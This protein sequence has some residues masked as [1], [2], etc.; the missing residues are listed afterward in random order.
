M[1]GVVLEAA[2][3][4]TAHPPVAGH[5]DGQLVSLVRA[6]DDRAFEELYARYRR[7]I[8]AYVYG[9]VSDHGRAEDVTQEVFVSALRRMRETERPIAFRPWIYEIAK[10]ACID[11]HRR[12]SRA[13]EVALTGDDGQEGGDRL[14]LAASSPQPE[15]AVDVKQRLGHLCGAF[16]GLSEAHHRILVLRELEGLSYRE[17]GERMGLSRPAVESTLFRARRRLA[18]EYDELASGSRCERV[19]AI[20]SAAAGGALA[21]REQRRMSRHL[22]HCETCRRHARSLGCGKGAPARAPFPVAGLHAG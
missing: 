1:G 19:R 2:A 15:E 13:E 10:N 14:H 18:R 9:M 7:R 20:V 4:T 6:G 12:G 8:T 16:G 21:P 17:I 3:L 5:D 11:A 22:V